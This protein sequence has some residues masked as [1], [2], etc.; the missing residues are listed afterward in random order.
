MNYRTFIPV[1]IALLGF[2]SLATATADT[3]L[4][5]SMK[6]MGK[7]YKELALDLQQPADAS[8]SDYLTL[9]GTMK[10]AAQT[11]RSLVPKKAAAL[12]TDQQDT[13]VQAYQKSM[14]DL[15]KSFDALTAAIQNSKW[16]DATKVMAQI[17]QQMIDGHKAFRTKH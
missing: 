7:A 5:N 8:K 10:T 17:K 6:Q 4:E 13:M 3:P 1:L 11:G 2:T 12:P 14:D 16:D 9:V 15:I